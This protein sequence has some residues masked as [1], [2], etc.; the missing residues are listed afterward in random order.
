MRRGTTEGTRQNG[1]GAGY[2]R[3]KGLGRIGHKSLGSQDPIGGDPTERLLARVAP[4]RPAGAGHPRQ[5]KTKNAKPDL[6]RTP[7]HIKNAQHTSSQTIKW[8]ESRWGAEGEG[9]IN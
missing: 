9:R 8:G 7:T 6:N 5:D 2:S 4:P 1:G 3:M